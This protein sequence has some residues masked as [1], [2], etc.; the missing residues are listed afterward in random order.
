MT[1]EKA[2][3]AEPSL[4]VDNA[5]DQKEMLTMVF[6]HKQSD[7]TFKT[8]IYKAPDWDSQESVSRVVKRITQ[9]QRRHA[10]RMNQARVE[11]GKE[12]VSWLAKY[13]TDHPEH[14]GEERLSNKEWQMITDAFNTNFS[15]SRSWHGISGICERK[16]EIREARK[17]TAKA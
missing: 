15:Q 11:Y 3:N 16:K 14:D 2:A 12:E 8:I 7:T 4:D 13:F 10:G 6:R 9:D 1:R 17:L 5:E